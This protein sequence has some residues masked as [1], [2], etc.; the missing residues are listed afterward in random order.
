MMRVVIIEDEILAQEEL[1]ALLNELDP[2]I[3]VVTKL[4]SVAKSIQWLKHHQHLADLLL[5][6][7][8]LLDGNSFDIFTAVS[9]NIPV[10]FVTAYDEY[11]IR[12]FKINSIDYLLKPIEPE[13]LQRA[14]TKY[15]QLNDQIPPVDW[16]TLNLMLQSQT[17]RDRFTIKIGDYYKCIMVKD[18][19]YF[20]ADDK[21]TFLYTF[22]NEKFVIDQSLSELE[23]GL[24]TNLFF[25]VTRRYLVQITAV[26]KASKYFHSRL[27]LSL[28]PKTKEDVLVSRIRV[29]EF[30]NWMNGKT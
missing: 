22:K 28:R 26:E 16:K 24:D 12:A 6:D 25:R 2:T 15:R 8:E 20:K 29:P 27:K 13:D 14:I 4:R 21:V 11:A 1:V 9:L 23:T 17:F 10:I 5:V 18:I 30:L 3:Q 7:I 19:A